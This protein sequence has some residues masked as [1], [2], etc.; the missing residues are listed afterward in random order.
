MRNEDGLV[1]LKF[2]TKASELLAKEMEVC[3]KLQDLVGN[4]SMQVVIENVRVL[5][6]NW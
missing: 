2:K 5:P 6:D 1:S 4:P 3:K